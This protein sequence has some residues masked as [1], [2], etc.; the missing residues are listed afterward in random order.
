MQYGEQAQ[1]GR[2][3]EAN[4]L[5][6]SREQTAQSMQSR[7]QQYHG[8]Y[9]YAGRYGVAA[10]RASAWDAA[11]AG[12]AAATTGAAIGAAA[13]AAM[14]VPSGTAAY[15]ASEPCASPRIVQSGGMTYFQCGSTWYTEAYGPAGPT[16]VTV[17][18]PF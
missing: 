10:A 13:G 3:Q 18:P 9:P 5:Q 4:S 8:N 17:Q 14:A 2:Q 11:A 6:S 7:A 15:A 1:T 12:A 16:F